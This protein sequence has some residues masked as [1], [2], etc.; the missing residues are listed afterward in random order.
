MKEAHKR[1]IAMFRF[2]VISE[3]VGR[4][5]VQRGERERI[6]GELSE[7]Q[8]EIPQSGRSSIGRSTIKE[9]LKRYEE[10]GRKL[11]SLFPKERSDAGSS[12]SM[13]SETELALVN[14]KREHPR[15]SLPVILLKARDQRIL[16]VDFKVSVQS[17][18]RIFKRHGVDR[19]EPVRKDRRRFEVE[20]PNELWQSDCMHGPKVMVE[21][22]LQKTYLFSIID[23]HS[24]LIPHAQFYPRENIDS[25]QDCLIQGL[26]KRG[27]PR[28]LYVDNGPCFRSGRLKYACASLG[29]ALIYASAYSPA[30][31][32]KQVMRTHHQFYPVS[33][34]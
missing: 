13:D 30:G 27:L 3:L 17:I 34:R 28:K 8:W 18:Y 9:W 33:S 14:L 21:G 1:A 25:Y 2:G 32:G 15:D 5:D 7:K 24:R 12:R 22:K 6:I 31:K 4:R 26:Q 11:E 29:I 20:F 10:S 19:L 23:D 16:P